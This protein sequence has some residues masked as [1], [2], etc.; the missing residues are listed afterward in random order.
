MEDEL[1]LKI[2]GWLNAPF[3]KHIVL[4][5]ARASKVATPSQLNLLQFEIQTV[6]KLDGITQPFNVDPH[7]S[8]LS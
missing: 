8:D 6:Q 7:Y 5:Q 3:W 1:W 4:D 2:N